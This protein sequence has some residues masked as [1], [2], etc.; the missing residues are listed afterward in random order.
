[1][2]IKHLEASVKLHLRLRVNISTVTS[3]FFII[4]LVII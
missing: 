3:C 1:M 4:F 2:K